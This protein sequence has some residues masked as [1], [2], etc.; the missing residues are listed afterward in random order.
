MTTRFIQD[1]EIYAEVICGIVKE[2]KSQLWLGFQ[3]FEPQKRDM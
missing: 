2:A 1:K 3:D